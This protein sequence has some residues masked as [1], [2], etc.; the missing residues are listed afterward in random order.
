[1][2]L[3]FLYRQLRRNLDRTSAWDSRAVLT[4][5][6]DIVA[7][8]SRGD[9]RSDLVKDVERQMDWYERLRRRTDIDERRL[10]GT[11]R[12]LQGHRDR[13]M[14]LGP[15]YLQSLRENEFLN[16]V[17]HRSA[18]P[19]GTCEFDLP[20]YTHWLRLPYANRRADLEHWLGSIEML[21]EALAEILWLTREGGQTLQ[22]VATNGCF[23]Q[24]LAKSAANNLLRIG[25]PATTDLYPEIS[26][27]HHRFTIRFMTW[28]GIG[29]RPE[30]FDGNVEFDLQVC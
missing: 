9:V 14:T 29:T 13:L 11:L 19:G 10:A 16:A 24:S 7:I 25:L 6:L 2:R 18:V 28:P 5:I 3:E 12:N 21:C 27:G 17:K 23:Q 15:Q 4:A 1:M 8:L 30:Q 26:A 20:E 22:V